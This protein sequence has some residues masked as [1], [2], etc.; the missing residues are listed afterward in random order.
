MSA[1][2]GAAAPE[3]ASAE[4]AAAA[5]VH[6]EKL[7]S[8]LPLRN[9]DALRLQSPTP[10]RRGSPLLVQSPLVQTHGVGTT[11]GASA[12]EEFDAEVALL[13][14]SPDEATAR[15]AIAQERLTH[16]V[17]NLSCVLLLITLLLLG[18]TVSVVT[19]LY[20]FLGSM[21]SALDS[22]KDTLSP[23]TLQRAVGSMQ[24]SLDQVYNA[25]GNVLN[26]TEDSE[27]L[28][29]YLIATV[30]STAS[31]MEQANQMGSRLLLHPTLTVALGGAQSPPGEL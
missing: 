2:P 4:A 25:T 23:A 28:A 18:F 8:R 14:K 24:G 30:N 13:A 21:T 9:G 17:R 16:Q 7:F 1:E 11:T 6:V 19:A 31:L 26:I 5:V 12:A 29:D 22:I 10:K 27:T 3:A 20:Q 15:A